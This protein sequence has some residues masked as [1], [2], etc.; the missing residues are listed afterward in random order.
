MYVLQ[1]PHRTG[2]KTV[3][4]FRGPRT[5]FPARN[6][7]HEPDNGFD[8]T[9]RAN[10]SGFSTGRYVVCESLSPGVY[11]F[12]YAGGDGPLKVRFEITNRENETLEESP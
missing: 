1:K 11:R 3:T 8:W 4:A 6:V 10:A 5:D 7:S 12:V 2:W 9:F